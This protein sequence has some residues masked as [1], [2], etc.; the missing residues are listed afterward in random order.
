MLSILHTTIEVFKHFKCSCVVQVPRFPSIAIRPLPLH[1]PPSLK[2]TLLVQNI[3][4]GQGF[5]IVSHTIGN[6]D[7][8]MVRVTALSHDVL[9]H[10]VS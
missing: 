2:F 5:P 4:I 9:P 3:Y 8:V 10:H 1:Q 6:S 7:L